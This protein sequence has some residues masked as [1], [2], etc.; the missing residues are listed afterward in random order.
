[1]LWVGAAIIYL[2]LLVIFGLTTSRRGHRALFLLGFVFP[3]LWLLGTLA[4]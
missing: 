2:N 4:G 1:M 3:P